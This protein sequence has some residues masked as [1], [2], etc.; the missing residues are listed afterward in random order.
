MK[1]KLSD[2]PI[3]NCFV[4]SKGE[5]KKKVGDRKVATV[6]MSGR[7]KTR[8]VK[9]NPEV[10]PSPCSIRLFGV[11]LRRHPD[12][13]VENGDGDLLKKRKNGK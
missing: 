8:K 12:I 1:I 5:M 9:G 6:A 13:M 4:N 11:G 2:L 10:E 3:L 7:V